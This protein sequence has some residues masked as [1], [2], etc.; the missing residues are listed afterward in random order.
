MS[1]KTYTLLDVI[2][3]ASWRVADFKSDVKTVENPDTAMANMVEAVNAVVRTLGRLKGLP[4]MNARTTINTDDD[5]ATG[6][7]TVTNGDATVT[8]SSAAFTSAMVGRAFA[9][10]S[11]NATY[12]IASYTDADNIELDKAWTDSTAAGEGYVI[13]QDRYDLP[14]DF[15]NILSATLEGPKCR[16]LD[17]KSSTEIARHRATQRTKTL[18][19]GAPTM[20]SVYDIASSGVRQCELDQ[21]P[22]DEYRV[23][24]QYMAVPSRLLHDNAV[25]PVFDKNIDILF[26]G[27]V[28]KW[29]SITGKSPEDQAAWQIWK[30]TDL[31]E[32]MAFDREKTDEL[33]V[34]VPE[35][36]MR[37]RPGGTSGALDWGTN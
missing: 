16:V 2:K 32:Y 31:P 23:V 28:A 35:D 33:T 25:V 30:R 24:L 29:R 19:V 4:M 7:V 14:T 15:G 34:I 26:D 21:F 6:T 3:I 9:T 11:K 37:S 17:I 10:N 36:V 20:I 8:G 1:A 12:R 22:D 5:H 13:A 27:V 18:S